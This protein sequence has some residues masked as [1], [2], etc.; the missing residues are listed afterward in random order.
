MKKVLIIVNGGIA[1]YVADP[2]IDVA[3]F[4]NDNWEQADDAE[5]EWMKKDM[6]GFEHLTPEWLTDLITEEV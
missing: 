6:K 1:D 5:R 3:V 2:D 4:D